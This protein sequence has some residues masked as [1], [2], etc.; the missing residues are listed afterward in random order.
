L[1]GKLEQHVRAD[2]QKRWFLTTKMPWRNAEGD[3]IGTL[4][5][6]RD[7]TD[8]QEAEAKVAETGSL[9]DILLEN[10][11][12]CIYFKDRK[13]RFVH[14]SQAFRKL[15]KVSDSLDLRG[16]TDFDF[17]T[18]EHARPAYED[19]Q[20]II[21]TGNPLVG[22]LERETHPDGRVTWCLTTKMAWR[23]NAGKIIGTFGTSK[24]V[25][26]IKEAEAKA[27]EMGVLLDTLLEHSP[28]CIYFKDRQSRFLHFSKQFRRLFNVDDSMDLRGKTDFD[29]FTEEH[30]R[31]AYED[32]QE[33]IR[34]GNPL[35]GKLEKETHA[36][37]R[38]TWCLTNKLPWR[39]KSGKII[40]TFGV[41]KDVT[42]MKQAEERLEQVHRQLLDT[43]RLAGMAEVATSVLHNVG[44]VLNSVNVAAQLLRE[45]LQQSRV[46]SLVKAATLIRKHSAHLSEFLSNDPK[47]KH[48]PEFLTEVSECL[49]KERDEM[50]GEIAELNKKIDHIK[51]IVA[52]QQ[53]YANVSGVV[54]IVK[55][56]E[57][58]EDALRMNAGAL[59]RHNVQVIRDYDPQV[60]EISV[61]KHKVL[62]ILVNLIRN[63]KYA[64]DE[65]NRPDKQLTLRIHGEKERV[66]ITVLDNGVGIP[67]EN[68]T[69]IFNHGF[70]T[71]KD[72]H[73]FG[74]HS[75]ALA[76]RE[77][78]GCL[79]AH[80]DGPDTGATFTLELP[81]QPSTV[82]EPSTQ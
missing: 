74:L 33:I 45:K 46:A 41:S 63:A 38:V 67:P 36:D 69:R 27:A 47:G 37:G 8:L 57:L 64:C 71:R 15:F 20:E 9:L 21:R 65:S 53:N 4:G 54:E 60:P 62:Q 1:I 66:R 12:D 3:I 59:S 78:G 10:S 48:L 28:D 34:T 77:M 42:A 17:F 22:K 5:V 13:S 52:M 6:S 14:F 7:V 39:S 11:P 24:D 43:S 29:F 82:N 23:N 2:G 61:D 26:A 30:A 81:V 19:E 40:G 68:L 16:K 25:T 76:A 79:T 55:V 73:G 70:T 49:A 75:G 58:A 18:D 35:I 44:N 80:S 31:P 50:L 56:S 32:E 72:G 51:D